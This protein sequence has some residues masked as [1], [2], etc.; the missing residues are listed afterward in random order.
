MKNTLLFFGLLLAG[1]AQAQ[2]TEQT[3]AQTT[4]ATETATAVVAQT[5]KV[6]SD[7]ITPAYFLPALGQFTGTEGSTEN[8]T[9]TVDEQNLGIVWVE[10]LAAGK[11]KAL[12]KQ[13][14]A[15]YKIPAQKTASGQSIPEGTLM[16][17]PETGQIKI[18]MGKSFDD[19]NPAAAFDSKATS[20]QKSYTGVKQ[21][22]E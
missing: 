8:L 13:S 4:A 14:P 10:G 21:V 5:A 11:F 6:T 7:N 2:T 15:T 1:A 12:L 18:L 22:T 16:V 3:E 20:K 9:V 19:A 17:T